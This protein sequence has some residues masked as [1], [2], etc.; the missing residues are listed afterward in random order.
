MAW[1][2]NEFRYLDKSSMIIYKKKANDAI[3]QLI[4]NTPGRQY[5]FLDINVNG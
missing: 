3:K 5:V 1:V 2:L 4:D